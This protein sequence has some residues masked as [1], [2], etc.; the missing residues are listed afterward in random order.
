MEKLKNI[1][2]NKKFLAGL[3]IAAAI[4][5]IAAAAAGY[6]FYRSY[7]AAMDAGAIER[8]GNIAGDLSKQ[9]GGG[10]LPSIDPRSNP[11]ENAPDTNP[12]SRTNPF[13]DIKTNPFE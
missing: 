12:V 6:R 1:L 7:K 11:M 8:A 9:A 2:R 3:A 4:L 13:T 5:L 10:T